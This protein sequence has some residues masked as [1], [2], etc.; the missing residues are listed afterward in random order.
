MKRPENDKWLD[1]ALSETIGS[2]KPWTDFKE[3]KQNH[4]EAVEMLTSRV[5]RQISASKHPL[6]IRRIIM[7]NQITKYAA[8]IALICTGVWLQQ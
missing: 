4:P 1:D 8:V 2:E 6:S 3:W 5:N 7:K